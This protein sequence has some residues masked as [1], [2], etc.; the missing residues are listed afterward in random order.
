VQNRQIFGLILLAM[1]V[2]LGFFVV[3]PFLAP[4]AWAAIFAYV[5]VPAYQRIMRPVGNRP[6]VAATVATLLLG[7]VLAIPVSFLLIRLQSELADA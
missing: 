3:K 1:S 5:T 6:S 4:L 2:G 7:L